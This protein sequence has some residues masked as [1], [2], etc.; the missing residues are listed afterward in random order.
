VNLIVRPQ[1]GLLVLKQAMGECVSWNHP[2]LAVLTDY[3]SEFYANKCDAKG[4]ADHGYERFFCGQGF[5]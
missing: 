1:F 4:H 5:R 2:V 3:G